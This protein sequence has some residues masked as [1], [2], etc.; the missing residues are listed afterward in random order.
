MK[1][2]SEIYKLLKK[3]GTRT[4]SR[5]WKVHNKDSDYDYVIPNHIYNQIHEMGINKV[6]TYHDQMDGPDYEG[7]P[8]FYFMYKGRTFNVISP[9]T[10]QD[11]QAW[12]WATEAMKLVD[13]YRIKNRDRRIELFRDMRR[14][15][16][17]FIF[18]VVP[19]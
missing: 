13:P 15:Y 2:F 19:F 10:I 1:L 7:N 6:V 18:D 4:G 5:V 16:I 9:H 8:T 12:I 17:E 14:F 11:Y 3:E